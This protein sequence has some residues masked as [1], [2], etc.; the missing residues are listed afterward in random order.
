MAFRRFVWAL[1]LASSPGL[2]WSTSTSWERYASTISK[3]YLPSLASGSRRACT[4][5]YRQAYFRPEERVPQLPAGEQGRAELR[6]PL[7]AVPL[8]AGAPQP[9]EDERSNCHERRAARFSLVRPG[10]EEGI[11]V[12]LCRKI[13]ERYAT[14]HHYSFL[15][16]N[17]SRVVLHSGL[18][19]GCSTT[20]ES[21]AT[22]TG[23]WAGAINSG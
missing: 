13:Q 5:L 4:H 19:A 16:G 23:G 20:N 15:T 17:N 7:T 11:K 10:T 9:I 1:N 12:K 2:E 14:H 8:G 3:E 6:A 21:W 22:V 18:V